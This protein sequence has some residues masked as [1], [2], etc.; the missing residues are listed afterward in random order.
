[1]TKNLA[2]AALVGL[3]SCTTAQLLPTDQ[4]Q[5]A[6]VDQTSV[7]KAEAYKRALAY[8]SKT[9]KDANHAIK[10][11]DESGGQIVADGNVE[12]DAFKGGALDGAIYTL[13][14]N[15]DFQA[16]DNKVRTS[17]ENLE[18]TTPSGGGMIVNAGSQISGP[19]GLAKAK[20]CVEP[21]RAALAKAVASEAVGSNW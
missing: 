8:L 11:R 19:E 4:R 7:K 21:V 6:F 1:M 15:L 13:K 20:A 17:F 12:C 3:S 9:Y 2:L 16:K 18:V 5:V 10:V 14:F